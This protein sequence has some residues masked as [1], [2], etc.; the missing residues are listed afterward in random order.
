[1]SKIAALRDTLVALLKEHERDGT[2]PTN[3]R[4]LFYELVQRGEISK[5]RTPRTDGKPGRRADQNLHDALIDVR[6][7]ERVVE[8]CIAAGL[9]CGEGFAVD[10]SLIAAD[11]NKQRSIPGKDWGKNRS[12]AKASRAVKEYLATL[13]DAARVRCCR[14]RTPPLDAAL[15]VAHAVW[16]VAGALLGGHPKERA[17]TRSLRDLTPVHEMGQGKSGVSSGVCVQ[18]FS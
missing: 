10:A 1:M 4:F 11:A 5:E 12:P 8:A 14:S 16:H 2:I 13:D 7:D 18:V 6:E 3:A 9:V 15:T 17:L